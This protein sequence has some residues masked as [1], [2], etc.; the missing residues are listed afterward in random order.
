MT[1]KPNNYRRPQNNRKPASVVRQDDRKTSVSQMLQE[2]IAKLDPASFAEWL[3]K[4]GWVIR[5]RHIARTA[6]STWIE[7]N[8]TIAHGVW[9]VSPTRLKLGFTES[10]VTEATPPKWVSDYINSFPVAA[11][12]EV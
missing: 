4:S 10:A 1:T 2:Q 6:L 8:Q 3:S 12:T 11:W 9:F 7:Q 5:H